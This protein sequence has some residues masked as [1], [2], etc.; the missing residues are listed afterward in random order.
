M[1]KE[2]S[3]RLRLSETERAMIAGATPEGFSEHA[4]LRALV[5]FGARHAQRDPEGLL[6]C[7]KEFQTRAPRRQV[8]S[9]P[10]EVECPSVK[11]PPSEEVLISIDSPVN[12]T[13]EDELEAFLNQEFS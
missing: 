11:S 4:T 9:G 12:T 13:P 5:R 3:V 2:S 6:A 10:E 7:L 1:K 8:T